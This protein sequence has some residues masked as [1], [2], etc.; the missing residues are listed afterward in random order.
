MKR[1]KIRNLAPLLLWYYGFI[2]LTVLLG[3]LGYVLMKYQRRR[4]YGS[5]T[6]F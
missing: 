5:A 3:A 2:L 1:H 4:R 6:S